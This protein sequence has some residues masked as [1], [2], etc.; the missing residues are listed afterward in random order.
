MKKIS[1]FYL[2]LFFALV[3]N[4]LH[5]YDAK[6][7]PVASSIRGRVDFWKKVY[8]LIPNT[9]GFIHSSKD[10]SIILS[11]ISAPPY[12]RRKSKKIVKREK[13]RI[14]KILNSIY[15]KNLKNLTKVEKKILGQF[16]KKTKAKVKEAMYSLRFQRGM[17]NRYLNGYKR[18]LLY[19]EK[20]KKI[21]RDLRLPVTL[22]YLPHV[23]SSFNYKA[24]SKVGAAGIWQFMRGSARTYRL[25]LNYILDERRDPL[26]AAYAAARMLKDNY[27]QLKTWPLALTA[28]NHGPASV[29]RAVRK[30]GSRK[31]SKI[32][33][34]YKGRRFGFASKNFYATFMATVEISEN[35]KK[36]F[37]KLPYAQPIAFSEIKLPKPMGM[38][39]VSKVTGFS[40][41]SLKSL[42]KGIRKTA[43]NNNL[44]LPRRYMIRIPKVSSSKVN[45]VN[46]LLSKVKAPKVEPGTII[47]HKVR[48]GES[49]YYIAKVYKLPINR[50][51]EFNNINN[52]SRIYPG[53]VLKIPLGKKSKTAKKKKK[54]KKKLTAKI[55]KFFSKSEDSVEK[56]KHPVASPLD[57]NIGD[58]SSYDLEVRRISSTRC[59]I[60]V[61]IEETL[62]H[63][64]DWLLVRSSILK[65]ENKMGRSNIVKLGEKFR[66][67]CND[68]SLKRFNS[69]RLEFHLAVQEDFFDE[70]LV[71]ST[72]PY[73]VR[74]GDSP[75]LI[76]RKK[77]IPSWLLR[78]Y[79]PGTTL[80]SLKIGDHLNIP[81]VV[82]K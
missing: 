81:L 22:A 16:P 62:G 46:N 7:F 11:T 17:R 80:N 70:Y 56:E 75:N 76:A 15:S 31:I 24:Y 45:E 79:N 52:P 34:H 2:I 69:E 55:K 57:L 40:L 74:P 33:N 26:R 29:K 3:D 78:T 32:I 36:Y 27:R 6:K 44:N 68:K 14:K 67:G 18:S 13:R 35:P 19:L 58:T 48:R 65:R 39:T 61:E 1:W 77:N 54:E 20:I 73:K 59:E 66:F 10:L 30:V 42:N 63:Y 60:R 25:K 49:L 43:Y 82:K 51:I 28:Y 4:Q 9:E 37:K 21:F 64:S 71:K 5:A 50:I 23:E 72:E 12:N 47:S 8:T 41:S 38:K 53:K